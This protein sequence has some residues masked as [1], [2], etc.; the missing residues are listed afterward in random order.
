M[1]DKKSV[2]FRLNIAYCPYEFLFLLEICSSVFLFFACY[3]V[4]SLSTYFSTY[5]TNIEILVMSKK[6]VVWVQ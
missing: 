6:E 4:I 2:Y 3:N 5:Y 1:I